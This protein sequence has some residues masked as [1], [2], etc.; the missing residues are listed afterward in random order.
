MAVAK[1]KAT[2]QS[3]AEYL[4]TIEPEEKR[5][6]SLALL[7]MFKQATGETAIMWGSAIVGFGSYVVRPQKGKTEARW[8]LVAFSPRKQNFTLYIMGGVKDAGLVK[9]LGKC[10]TS[11]GCL[12]I[13]KL[14][15]VDAK[16]LKTMV[17][18]SFKF[19][20]ANK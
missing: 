8:P 2:S 16:I 5:N 12:Y 15:D 9:K 13:N 17:K 4:N 19:N 18:E 6:D 10:K 1:T 7:K 11:G 3:A 14:S 20:K